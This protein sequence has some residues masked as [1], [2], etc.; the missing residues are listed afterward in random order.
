MEAKLA[1]ICTGKELEHKNS[2]VC[3]YS[4]TNKTVFADITDS[5]SLEKAVSYWPRRNIASPKLKMQ[6]FCQMGS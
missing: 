1:I 4:L 6:F 5:D 3:G 2:K